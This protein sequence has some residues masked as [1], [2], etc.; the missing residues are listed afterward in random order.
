MK[1]I[2][3]AG[4]SGFLGWHFAKNLPSRYKLIGVY[5]HT[6][7][8]AKDLRFTQLDLRDFDSF[9]QWMDKMKPDAIINLAAISNLA[10]VEDNSDYAYQI[11]VV[12]PA[13]MANYAFENSLPYVYTSSDQVFDGQEGGYD[14]GDIPSPIHLYGKQ[15][16]EAE[17]LKN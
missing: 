4:I 11:N 10:L 2:L 16:F 12:I 8:L 14:F 6:K 17:H 9:S 15:K 1:R 13:M 3:V 7:D 5:N